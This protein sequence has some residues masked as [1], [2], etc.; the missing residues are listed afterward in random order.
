MVTFETKV[1]END[2]PMLLCSG[3]LKL[4][5]DRNNF[6]FPR[7]QL[8][9]N[10]VKDPAK[11]KAAAQLLVD[12]KIL[13]D[14]YVADD[15]A[16]AALDHFGLARNDFGSGY[17]YSIAE[18]VGIYLCPTPYLLH[19]S[20][21]SILMRRTDWIDKAISVMEKNDCIKA[22]NLCWN[23]QYEIAKREAKDMDDDFF[24]GQGF[25][26][27]CYLIRAQD[28]QQRIYQET[29]QASMRYPA[30]GGELF[31]K[32]VDAWLRNHGYLRATFR[33]G[34]YRHCNFP[35]NRFLKMIRKNFFYGM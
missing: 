5:I 33:F 23:G 35:K 34:S 30:Y 12:K 11:V 28:F 24:F 29:N 26:D 31:E 14:Y 21:D 20:S 18:L 19:F 7:R 25:S 16:G 10:N 15:Y 27:Q 17:Y 13:T 1:W 9:I 32:R 6:D 2:W 8:I 4:M 22:A 3:R